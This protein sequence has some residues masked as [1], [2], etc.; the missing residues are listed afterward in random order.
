MLPK[1]VMSRRVVLAGA[2]GLVVV[3]CDALPRVV[4]ETSPG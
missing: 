4:V 2:A 3:G 1:A